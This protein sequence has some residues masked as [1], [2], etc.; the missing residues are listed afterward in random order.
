MESLSFSTLVTRGPVL[1]T[2]LEA[3]GMIRLGSPF[4]IFTVDLGVTKVVIPRGNSLGKIFFVGSARV[5]SFL[6]GAVGFSWNP[7]RT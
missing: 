4:G 7:K 1:P 6:F 5:F 3:Q 2:T